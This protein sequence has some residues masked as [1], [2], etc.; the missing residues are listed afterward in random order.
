M[1]YTQGLKLKRPEDVQTPPAADFPIPQLPVEK[2]WRCMVKGCN[3]MCASTK[4][5]KNHWPAVHSRKG[6]PGTQWWPTLLQ[7]FFRGRMLLYFT[8]H[9]QQ[10]S[11]DASHTPNQVTR[12]KNNSIGQ[13]RKLP[14]STEKHLQENYQLDPLDSQLLRHYFDISYK[15]FVSNKNSEKVW[16]QVVPELAC[17]HKFLLQGILA[18]TALHMAHLS[19]S[20]RQKY[21]LRGCCHQEHAIPEFRKAIENPTEANCDAIVAFGY[22]LVIYSLAT[23][24]ENCSNPL[25]LV[26]PN[27]SK[28]TEAHLILPM[29]L[30]FI[31]TGCYMLKDVWHRIETG[32]ASVLA[33]AWERNL[34]V[35]DEE[36]QVHLERFMS[37]VANQSTWSDKSIRLYSSAA[38]VLAESFAFVDR[39][40]KT[41]GITPWNILGTW[42]VRIEEEFFTLI[43]GNH[44]GALILLAY[45]CVILNQIQECWYFEGRP[46]CLI[47]AIAHILD[48]RWHHHI[49]S[50][51]N[52]VLGPG[53]LENM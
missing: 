42:P 26:D 46:A 36:T 40:K 32:Q 23:D 10:E 21:T 41:I 17:S 27:L 7:T 22:L 18:C 24:L 53:G 33:S 38:K 15:T 52:E 48:Q 49:Q 12:S 44:P 13:P 2:G 28:S 50:A 19:P 11:Q 43:S 9:N 31:R 37:V 3:S 34:N 45:C 35:T 51:I 20:E 30:Q 1:V 39:A 16:S 6:S 47:T 4:R 8:G 5:M 14:I 25:L 29:W